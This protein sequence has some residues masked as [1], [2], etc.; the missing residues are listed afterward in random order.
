M[1]VDR[2]KARPADRRPT[3]L[4]P[5]VTA[6]PPAGTAGHRAAGTARRAPAP[7]DSRLPATARP[8]VGTAH[9]HPTAHLKLATIPVVTRPRERWCKRA[10]ARSLPRRKPESGPAYETP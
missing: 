3:A 1:A 10:A 7:M 8:R 2:R 4:L 9:R 5:R 6:R